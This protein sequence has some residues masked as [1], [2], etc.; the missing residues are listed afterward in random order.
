MNPKTSWWRSTLDRRIYGLGRTLGE[1]LTFLLIICLA[2]GAV[3]LLGGCSG[4][5]TTRP[6]YKVRLFETQD[7]IDR[8]HE[9]RMQSL[10]DRH[11]ARIHRRHY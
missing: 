1:A 7:Q 9:L 6:D 4:I 10:R 8:K 11:R 2:A 3:A 5:D